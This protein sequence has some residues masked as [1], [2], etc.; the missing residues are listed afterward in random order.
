MSKSRGNVVN[1]DEYVAKFGADAL[2]LY[3]MFM[4]PMDGYPDFRDAGI[5]GSKRFLD[6]LWR[7]FER[8]EKD[9]R[10]DKALTAKMHQTIK[11]V[12][13]YVREYKYNTA[14]AS[15]M[16]YFNAISTSKNFSRGYLQ[17]LIILLAPF[18][19]HIA[20]EIWHSVLGNANSIHLSKWPQYDEKYLKSDQVNIVIQINGKLRSGILVDANITKDEVLS[21]AKEDEKVIKWLDGK[22]VKKEIYVEGK[23]INFVV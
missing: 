17:T 7:A 14:I 10:E 22:N 4:G 9:D 11:K 18:V 13:D 1:P 21:M 23:L 16:E 5:E 3:L 8:M 19:P 2:R 6:K 20:E 15:L 12:T